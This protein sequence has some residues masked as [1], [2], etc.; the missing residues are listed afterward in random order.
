MR[1]LR[2]SESDNEESLLGGGGGGGKTIGSF[3]ISDLKDGM[4]NSF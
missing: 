1:V 3:F 4:L 2:K